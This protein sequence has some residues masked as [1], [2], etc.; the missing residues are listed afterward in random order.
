MEKL[1]RIIVALYLLNIM[2]ALLLFLGETRIT[3]TKL[4]SIQ[5]M[6]TMMRMKDTTAQKR[7][8]TKK[9]V[10][11]KMTTMARTKK[12]RIGKISERI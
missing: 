3:T 9:S 12:K 2:T 11:T 7:T 8:M 4:T 1:Y 10:M 5:A 6:T